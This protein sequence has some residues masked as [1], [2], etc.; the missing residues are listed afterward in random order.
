[1]I[2]IGKQSLALIGTVIAFSQ[3]IFSA[4]FTRKQ[5]RTEQTSIFLRS[6]KMVVADRETVSAI[7]NNPANLSCPNL[8]RPFYRR[9]S[10]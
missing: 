4:C 2:K 8:R 7:P 9:W 3:P 5:Q 1:M 6:P 10:V